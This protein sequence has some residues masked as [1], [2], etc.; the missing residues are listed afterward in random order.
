MSRYETN[1]HFYRQRKFYIE[2]GGGGTVLTAS[3]P[4][5]SHVV[6][7]G[8]AAT[9]D[10]LHMLYWTFCQYLISRDTDKLWTANKNHDS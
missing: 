9:E 3:T 6:S 2:G 8:W 10:N 4:I 5:Y 1:H 7:S